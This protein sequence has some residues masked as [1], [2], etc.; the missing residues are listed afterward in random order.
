M[1]ALRNGV[2]ALWITHDSRTAELTD[3]LH[4]PKITI[5]E[6]STIKCL[7]ELLEYCDYTELRKNYY[8]L[9]KNYVD[10]LTENK[11][12]H[13]YNLTYESGE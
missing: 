3:F 8:D 5:K 6:F 9:C 11:L 2:P 12:A 7:D 10:Y 13:K 4:L 1:E